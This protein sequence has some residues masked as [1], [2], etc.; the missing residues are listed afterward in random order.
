MV[1]Q[2]WSEL[3]QPMVPHPLLVLQYQETWIA[4]LGLAL[5]LCLKCIYKQERFCW[6]S[7]GCYRGKKLLSTMLL[8]LVMY[9]VCILPGSPS[10]HLLSAVEV[11][12]PA[13]SPRAQ[14]HWLLPVCLQ[15]E[16]GWCVR[17]PL[18]LCESRDTRWA[19]L[20]ELKQ[21]SAWQAAGCGIHIRRFICTGVEHLKGF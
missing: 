19:G 16:A 9:F 18:P 17:Q 6:C 8:V 10:C 7:H 5:I 20:A 15:S 1:C 21:R 13:E 4:N 11:A 14:S 2:T 3:S 12:R